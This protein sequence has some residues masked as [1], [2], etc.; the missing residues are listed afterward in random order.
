M[1]AAEIDLSLAHLSDEDTR[2]H[3]GS[4]P[5][6]FPAEVAPEP[7]P[8]GCPNSPGFSRPVPLL[9]A[10]FL[11]SIS[12]LTFSMFCLNSSCTWAG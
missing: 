10:N 9:S 11:R 7:D 12:T 8:Q 6:S 2:V 3:G 4:V 5:C 1:W